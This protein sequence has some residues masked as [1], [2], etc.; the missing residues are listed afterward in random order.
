[1]AGMCSTKRVRRALEKLG[2]A[3]IDADG[4]HYHY[5]APNGRTITIVLGH[6]EISEASLKKTCALAGVAWSD[7]EEQY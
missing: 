4:S 1:M 3:F 7:F 5:R 2:L 6:T